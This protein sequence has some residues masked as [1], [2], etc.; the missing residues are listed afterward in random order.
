MA[1]LPCIG[2]EGP[3]TK[4]RCWSCAIYFHPFTYL[5]HVHLQ[6]IQAIAS[7]ILSHI[8]PSSG[9]AGSGISLI[10]WWFSS[11]WQMKPLESTDDEV[12]QVGGKRQDFEECFCK[13]TL[14]RGESNKKNPPKIRSFMVMATDSHTWVVFFVLFFFCLLGIFG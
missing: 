2:L 9:M 7:R 10:R 12:D 6:I 14:N 4:L 1:E 11:A 8:P 5:Y 3:A 13:I